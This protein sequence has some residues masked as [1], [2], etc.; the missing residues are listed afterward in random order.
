[1]KGHSHMSL[2]DNYIFDLDENVTRTPVSYTNRFGITIAADLY[3]PKDFDESREYA[4][5]IVGAPYGGVRSRVPASTPRTWPCAD[6]SRSPS[7]PRST[8]TA[9]ASRATS[10][11]PTSSSRTSAQPSTTW[12]HVP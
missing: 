6:S 12:A 10:P 5:V 8:A 4:A 2:P 1:M 3:R 11:R 9:A 7:T